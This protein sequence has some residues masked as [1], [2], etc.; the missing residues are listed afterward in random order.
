MIVDLRS[1]TVTRPTPEMRKA[2]AEAEVGDDV[3]NDDPT[4][5]KL[6][7]RVAE[8]FGKEGALFVPSGTMANQISIAYHTQPG[9]E[10][11]GDAGAH[12]FNFEGGAPA[13][14]WGVS[15]HPI[16]GKN[17]VFTAE[18][19]RKRLRPSASHFPQS[20][21][22]WVENSHN[23]AGGTIFPQNEIL[24]LR[25]LATEYG[26]SFHLDGARIWNVAIATGMSERQLA[27]PFDSL[28]CCLSKGLGCPVGSLVIGSREFI[29]RAHRFRKR[30]GGG[31]RQVG[32]LAAAGLYALDHHR[33]RLAEDHR[34]AQ[35]LAEGIAH[36]GKFSLDLSTVQT[37]I[38]IFDVSPLSGT[39][40]VERLR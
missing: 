18:E 27:E 25:Q 5:L 19:V 4:V 39:E 40:V 1:D 31:M 36:L 38:V 37:N 34:R 2:M 15:F 9:D 17:G 28:S 35:R 23:R 13:A 30:L 3:F 12:I 6:Q 8:I 20:R 11:Y 16:E 24:K 29:A 7:E 10:I 32:I 22:I 14:L 21:L 26:L 33:E